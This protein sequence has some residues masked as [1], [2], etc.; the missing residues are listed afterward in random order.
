MVSVQRVR[1]NVVPSVGSFFCLLSWWRKVGYLFVSMALLQVITYVASKAFYRIQGGSYR[2]V[3]MD[4]NASL[5]FYGSSF[6]CLQVVSCMQCDAW[7]SP[8]FVGL[9]YIYLQFFISNSAK[10]CLVQRLVALYLDQFSV[11]LLGLAFSFRRVCQN[12]FQDGIGCRQ[13][14]ICERSCRRKLFRQYGC[15]ISRLFSVKAMF[16]ALHKG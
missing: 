2:S 13:G 3:T 15:F 4:L 10:I 16:V 5:V 11:R 14:I 8:F 7:S 6:A 12:Y 9:I 1:V